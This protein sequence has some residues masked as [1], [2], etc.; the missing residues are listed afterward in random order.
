[1]EKMIAYYTAPALAGIKPSNI[2]SCNKDKVFDIH[3]QI[4]NLNTQMNCKDIY[5]KAINECKKR[6]LVMVYRK[7]VLNKYLERPEIKNL[8]V[9]YGYPD[10]DNVDVYLEVLCERLKESEFPH[11][12]G[13]FLGYPIHDIYGF[14]HHKDE[15]CLLCGEWKVYKNCED[16]QKLFKRFSDCR[17]AVIKR[18]L[19]G[20]T[21]AQ[22]FCVA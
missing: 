21:L 4:K 8:L 13:A 20:E 10:C 18:L 14:I 7:K 11:E 6:V 16:A 17:K 12:I 2:F 15:G 1:M 3:K 19:L 9:S 5:F 22:V